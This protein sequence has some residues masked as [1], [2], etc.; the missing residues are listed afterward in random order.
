M[1]SK[2]TISEVAKA[3]GVSTTTVSRVMSGTG[4][5]SELTRQRVFSVIEQLDYQP[6]AIAKGLIESKTYNIGLMLSP[7][8]E[9]YNIY[10]NNFFQLFLQGIVS[11]LKKYQYDVVIAYGDE[12]DP[13]ALEK[14]IKRQKVEG[15]ILIKS[16]VDSQNIIKL[17]QMSF[18]FVVVGEPNIPDVNF[19]DTNNSETM[20]ELTQRLAETCDNRIA[21]IASDKELYSNALHIESYKKALKH[22]KLS[23]NNDYIYIGDDFFNRQVFLDNFIT[24]S[25]NDKSIITIDYNSLLYTINFLRERDIKI[26][27]EVQIVTF[28]DNQ[29]L[30]LFSPSITSVEMPV[31]EMGE[32]AA[33]TLLNT[34][35]NEETSDGF[36]LENTIMYR[37][38]TR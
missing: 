11:V 6:S 31:R 3:A 7:K 10:E 26:P 21:L 13:R 38:S 17:K 4:R 32:K 30:T 2:V 9:D 35:N 5:I 1:R 25:K 22:R 20:F 34:I 28:N 29:L 27:E 23:V 36:I 37:E 19:I 12:K 33:L 24:D 8:T 14:F 18:P 16:L 15:L